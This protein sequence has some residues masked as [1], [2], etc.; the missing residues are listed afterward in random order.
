[1]YVVNNYYVIGLSACYE[2][3]LIDKLKDID[4]DVFLDIYNFNYSLV[5]SKRI[6]IL[7]DSYNLCIR[8]YSIG[9]DSN[10]IKDTLNNIVFSDRFIIIDSYPQKVN[11][12]LSTLRLHQKFSDKENSK[13][14]LNRISII[15]ILLSRQNPNL[16]IKCINYNIYISDEVL[17]ININMRNKSIR[18]FYFKGYINILDVF[19]VLHDTLDYRYPFN[20]EIQCRGK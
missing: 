20:M 9:C 12:I 19:K 14:F 3:I 8:F 16:K 18:V 5:W 1:M 7:I 13:Y 6:R 15:R 11:S 17:M 4:K 2:K 10:S